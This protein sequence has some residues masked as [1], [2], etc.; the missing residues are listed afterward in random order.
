MP[1][2]IAV[3]HWPALS[4]DLQLAGH[5]TTSPTY[6]YAGLACTHRSLSEKKET[7]ISPIAS[8]MASKVLLVVALLLAATF[9][10]AS[11]NE[12]AREFIV[13]FHAL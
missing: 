8:I 6:K 4:I 7:E 10:A 11:A 1:T 3:D 13:Q 9:L 5:P 2:T 12:Q